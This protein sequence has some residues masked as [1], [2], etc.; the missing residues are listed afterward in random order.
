M[1]YS[2]KAY[3]GGQYPEDRVSVSDV[4]DGIN[5]RSE[6]IVSVESV[7]PDHLNVL[8]ITRSK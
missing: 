1:Y 6:I 3:I 4:L 8:I 2:Y 5:R 7:G